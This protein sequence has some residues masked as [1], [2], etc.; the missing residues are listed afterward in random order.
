MNVLD[1]ARRAGVTSHWIGYVEVD[2]VDAAFHRIKQLGGAACVPQTNVPTSA[3]FDPRRPAN[4]NACVGQGAESGQAQSAERR[5]CH[6]R[7]SAESD[8]F[9]IEMT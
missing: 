7:N 1:D 6:C 4:G 5:S 3:A 8:S 9:L 2:D